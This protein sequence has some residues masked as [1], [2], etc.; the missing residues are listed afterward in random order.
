MI[1]REIYNRNDVFVGITTTAAIILISSL[2]LAPTSMGIK[3]AQALIAQAAITG[4][5][6]GTLV[7]SGFTHPG[8][9]IKFSATVPV[10]TI[11]TATGQLALK[12]FGASAQGTVLKGG[13]SPSSH[14]Y[15]IAGKIT[16]ST[17]RQCPAGEY[18][19][20]RG[21]V[22]TNVPITLGSQ[23]S[24]LQGRFKGTVSAAPE[25]TAT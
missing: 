2:L 21:P 9:Q 8:T 22:G 13:Y 17:Y 6:K 18:F 12:S 10:G 3:N 24:E 16:S 11:G 19:Y 1:S 15:V 23:N 20:V 4:D 25:P 5:G 14:T 7:C